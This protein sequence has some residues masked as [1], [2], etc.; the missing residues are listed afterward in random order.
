MQAKIRFSSGNYH[1]WDNISITGSFFPILLASHWQSLLKLLSEFANRS[2]QRINKYK[3]RINFNFYSFFCYD[4]FSIFLLHSY[5][6]FLY[7]KTLW[8]M[9]QNS[10]HISLKAIFVLQILK[11]LSWLFSH[12]EKQLDYKSKVNFKIYDVTTKE[13]NNCNTHIAQYLKK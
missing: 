13:T 7:L 3:K 10:F 11:V 9:L 2:N 6:I 4:D 12:G 1:F 5:F 8:K